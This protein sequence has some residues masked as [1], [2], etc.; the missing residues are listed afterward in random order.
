MAG[1]PGFVF[2]A[3]GYNAGTHARDHEKGVTVGG[4]SDD[5]KGKVKESAGKL[6]DDERLEQ[7]GKRDQAKGELK[8]AVESVKDAAKKLQP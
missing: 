8:D 5:V 7:E 1:S 3:S 4:T 6:T 2:D